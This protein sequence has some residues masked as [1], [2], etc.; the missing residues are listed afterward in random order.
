V[1]GIDRSVGFGSIGED[2]LDVLKVCARQAGQTLDAALAQER[3]SSP[4]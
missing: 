1:I 4:G 2:E 3:A